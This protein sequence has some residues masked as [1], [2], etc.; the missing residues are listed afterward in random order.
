MEKYI[1]ILYLLFL[2][3]NTSFAVTKT[4]IANGNWSS[5]ST[6][7]PS[8]VPTST[9][10][11]IINSNVILDA[12]IGLDPGG[13]LTINSGKTLIQTGSRTLNTNGTLSGSLISITNNG[14]FTIDEIQSSEECGLVTIDNFGTMN[15][16]GT[17]GT[18]FT[19]RSGG[20]ITNHVGATLNIP[21]A[22]TRIS[23]Q[24]YN[25][26]SASGCSNPSSYPCPNGRPTLDNYGTLNV[27]DLQ[28]H[29][30][31]VGINRSTGIIN[32][33]T[34]GPGLFLA[35]YDFEN[36]GC[37]I[38]N[39]DIDLNGKTNNNGHNQT[40]FHDGSKLVLVA[41]VFSISV[42]GHVLTGVDDD[43]NNV[44]NA[45]ISTVLAGT[46]ILNSG[47]ITGE[48][49]INDPDGNIPGTLG[50]LI[51]EGTSDCG[52]ATC[53]LPCPNPNCGTA[54]IIKN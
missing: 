43:G 19:W 29:A 23:N 1:S 26:G 12:N 41:G 30:N 25:S 22:M 28:F 2:V 9:D 32:T 36:Y 38:A 35:A 53:T 33:F 50:P 16:V 21:T 42:S 34:G 27:W 44:N 39:S 18:V 52:G 47:T 24:C 7:S 46:Q 10:D 4:S 13:S 8:G 20:A 48:L 54:T 15:V 17:S 3:H 45:C 11:I 14:T 40:T 51:V 6:W 31:S 37:I 5:A 49:F